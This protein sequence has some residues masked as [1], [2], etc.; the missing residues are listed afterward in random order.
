MMPQMYIE[1]TMEVTR[2]QRDNMDDLCPLVKDDKG[3]KNL[4]KP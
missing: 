1:A 3:T 2:S 4:S